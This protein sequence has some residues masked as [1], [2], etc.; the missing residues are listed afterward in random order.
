MTSE[1]SLSSLKPQNIPTL[2]PFWIEK[3]EWKQENHVQYP[4]YWYWG[5]FGSFLPTP[6]RRYRKLNP[7][8]RSTF[9]CLPLN[10]P[11]FRYTRKEGN[12]TLVPS[13]YTPY[14]TLNPRGTTFDGVSTTWWPPYNLLR[15]HT[16]LPSPPLKISELDLSEQTGYKSRITSAAPSRT[17]ELRTLHASL[18]WTWSEQAYNLYMLYETDCMNFVSKINHLRKYWLQYFS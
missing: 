1:T 11:S 10:P 9:L 3:K 5:W 6:W 14:V 2:S 12:F 17:V 16:N 13:Q 7:L 15:Q 4:I 8:E 18:T